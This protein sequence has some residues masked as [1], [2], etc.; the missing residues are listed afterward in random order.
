[1]PDGEVPATAKIGETV[2]VKFTLK[3]IAP[4][5]K[6]AAD[7][8]GRTAGGKYMGMIKWGGAPK[9][10]ESGKTVVFNILVAS[11]P[12]LGSVH[13]ASHLSPTGEFKD[14]VKEAKSA[15]IKIV[16]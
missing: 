10:A 9:A 8:H 4:G 14:R 11:K 15:E 13:V 2:P 1:M 16:Q 5:L 7:L 3:D 6:L 12:D